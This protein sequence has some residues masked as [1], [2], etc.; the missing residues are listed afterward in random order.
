MAPCRRPGHSALPGRDG[1]IAQ[2]GE[3]VVRNDEVGG[4]I[5]PGSTSLRSASRAWARQARK[6]L[7]G[8]PHPGLRSSKIS[9][10][11][12]GRVRFRERDVE[13]TSSPCERGGADDEARKPMLELA[14]AGQRAG[15]V[16]PV[17]ATCCPAGSSLRRPL[18]E[19]AARLRTYEVQFVPGLLQTK[20]YARAVITAGSAGVDIPRRSRPEGRPAAGT[21]APCL[22]RPPAAHLHRRSSTRRR[23]AAHRRFR[24]DAGQLQHLIELMDQPNVTI[25][26]MPFHFGGHAAEG[27]AFSILRFPEAHLPR[28]VYVEQLGSASSISTNARRSTATARSWSGL[29]AGPHHADP[30]VDILRKILA[31][32][33]E[34]SRGRAALLYAEVWRWTPRRSGACP[35]ALFVGAI[36]RNVPR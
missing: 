21:P 15:L 36:A 34:A 3:R 23:C 2:L 8:H 13:P 12:L 7:A 33:S 11:E 30:E 25:Q 4:S 24:R 26:V 31:A 19:A 20:E 35:C 18:E 27:G 1:A 17:S 32:S 29:C 22:E 16:V 9:R 5:P 14:Q 6:V 10:M 28:I